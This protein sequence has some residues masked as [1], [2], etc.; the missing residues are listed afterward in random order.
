MAARV[1]RGASAAFVRTL[2]IYGATAVSM[3]VLTRRLAP[4]EFGVYAVLVSLSVI[5]YNF[6]TA[7]FAYTF[8]R[9]E[10]VSDE[11]VQA[12]FWSFETLY[13]ILAIVLCGA[14]LLV[15]GTEAH[16][17]LRGLAAFLVLA[18]FRFPAAVKCWRE[19]QLGR[20]ALIEAS[21]GVTFQL[22]A[23]VLVLAGLG[24]PAFA[25]ALAAAAA[26]SASLSV[27]LVGWRPSLPV[28]AP[29]IPWWRQAR[30]YFLS[31]MLTLW[32]DYGHTPVIALALGS[33]AAGYFGW[34][35][36][37]ATAM[38]ALVTVLTQAAFVGFARVRDVG[39]TTDA[40]SRALRLLALGLGGVLAV[41]AGAAHPIAAIVFAPKWLPAVACMRFLMAA[42]AAGSLLTV[43]FNL[44]LADGR[45]RHANLWLLTVFAFTITLALGAGA[46]WGV[47]AYAVG[48]C[49]I[50]TT[51]LTVA[52]RQTTRTYHLP[53]AT[54]W[55][56]LGALACTSAA[57]TAGAVV[58]ADMGDT[59]ASLG[60]SLLTSSALYALLFTVIAR[61][62]PV[63]E[64]RQLLATMRTR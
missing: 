32:R 4:R 44:A 5:T 48:Y 25:Y 24:E 30:P 60:A 57:A 55:Y 16:V 21:E 6:V 61:G 51:T 40:L 13:L 53:R 23:V 59:V 1:V 31:S 10:S 12:A 45:V 29:L 41:A 58:A 63:T 33:V 37:I 39:R 49:A 50:M 27:L 2:V 20:L 8:T 35:A 11:V 54:L 46:I 18:P 14:S 42:V 43:F 34:A 7:G 62:A 52:W 36:G 9:S 3:L 64:V 17:L 28:Y 26:A 56:V 22:V 19:V 47:T 15:P 38:T